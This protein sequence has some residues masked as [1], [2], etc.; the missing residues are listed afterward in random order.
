MDFIAGV[1]QSYRLEIANFLSTFSH[2]KQINTCH[3]VP[4]QDNFFKMT[5]FCIAFFFLA[6]YGHMS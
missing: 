3:K 6:F 4:L 2:V 1:Y 5:K